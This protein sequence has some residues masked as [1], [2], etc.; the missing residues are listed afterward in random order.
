[1]DAVT[2]VVLADDHPVYRQGL[3]VFLSGLPDIELV[4]VA[5]N[6]VEA[7]AQVEDLDADVALLDLHMPTMGG[8][9]A[10]R[11]LTDRH[12]QVAVLVLTMYEDDES[13]LAAIRAGAQGYLVKGASG[14]RIVAAIRAVAAGEVVFGAAA[15][16]HIL[17]SVAGGT[18]GTLSQAHRPRIR[19]AQ[20][21]SRRPIQPRH[22]QISLSVRENHS[23]PCLQHLRQDRRREPLGSNRQGA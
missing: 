11:L 13:V 15:G 18:T 7:L 19:R 4:G 6:G 10:T 5:S 1:M 17:G 2:R 12:P 14:E 9:E 21:D 20:S 23:Q 22:S 3:T 16:R 8:I